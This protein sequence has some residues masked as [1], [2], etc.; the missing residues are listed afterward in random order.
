VGVL[1]SPRRRR[2]LAWAGSGALVAGGIAFSMIYWANTGT[3]Y[4]LAPKGNEPIDVVAPPPPPAPFSAAREEGV[5]DTA[6]RFLRTA[7]VREHVEKSWEL[8]APSLK[9]GYTPRSWATQDIPVQPYPVESARWDVDY[10][11]EGVVGLKVA[12]FPKRG[13]NVPAAVFDMQLRAFGKGDK[14]RW[15]VDSWTPTSYTQVPS[16][17][18]LSTRNQ[19]PPVYRSPLGASWLFLPLSILSLIVLVPLTVLVRGWLR[20]RRATRR[21]EASLH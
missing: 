21:Y 12:L 5:L 19:S 2:R 1:S 16:G 3:T 18:L 20:D 6:T 8:T 14:R 13:T 11:W 10:S 7:V 4:E 9:A 17:P 15:L